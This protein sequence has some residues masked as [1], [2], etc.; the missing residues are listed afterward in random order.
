MSANESDWFDTHPNAADDLM[1]DICDW[2]GKDQNGKD[3]FLLAKNLLVCY[4]HIRQLSEY[5]EILIN[6]LNIPDFVVACSNIKQGEAITH[7]LFRCTTLESNHRELPFIILSLV[8]STNAIQVADF[9]A[10]QPK[11]FLAYYNRAFV[12]WRVFLIVDL[13]SVKEC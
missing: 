7:F 13:K 5:P 11:R 9:V 4:L 3:V 10:V 2:L 12:Y 8:G 6:A 1:I